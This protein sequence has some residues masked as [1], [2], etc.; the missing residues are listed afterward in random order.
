MLLNNLQSL[1]VNVQA[2][3]SQMGGEVR[4]LY[5]QLCI[6]SVILYRSLCRSLD[7]KYPRSCRSFR[8]VFSPRNTP[9]GAHLWQKGEGSYEY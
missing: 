6:A 5:I 4:K 3:F 7:L 2:L 8:A 9:L 1:R